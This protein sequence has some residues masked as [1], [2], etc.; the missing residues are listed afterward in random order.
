MIKI[1]F[2]RASLFILF[3]VMLALYSFDGLSVRATSTGPLITAKASASGVTAA[4]T[5]DDD[6]D[7]DE[8]DFEFRGVIEAL[9]NTPGFIGDWTVSGRTVR[10]GSATEIE[11]EDG[12]VMVGATVEVEGF[13]QTDNSVMAKEIEVES[14]PG[15]E[16]EFEGVVE[17]LPDTMGRIGDWTVSGTVVH[18][19]AATMIKQEGAPVAVG[20]KVE[21]EGSKRADGSVDAFQIEVEDDIDDDD[22]DGD[23]EFKGAIESLPDTPGRIGEWS[24][25]GRKVNVTAA[26][27]INPNAASVAVG[28]VVEVEGIK[29]M[30]AQGS[31]IDAKE[32]EV[33][34]R[35]GAG[36]NFVQFH[37]TVETLPGTPGQIGVWTVSG[38]MVNVTANTKIEMDGFPVAVGSKVEVKGALN[39]DGSINAAKIE[40]EDRD[41]VDDEFEFKGVI[42][43][44]PSTPDLVGDWKVSGRTVRVNA[45][46]EIERDYGMVMVG[47]FVEVEGALQ[48]DNS[49][50]AAEIE[51]KQGR[52]GGAYMNFNQVTTVSAAG[53]Q[54]ENAPG[55]IV[56]AFGVNMSSTTAF[57]TTQPLPYSL[58]NV[59]VVVD[60]KLARLFFVSRN[61][62]NYQ[63]PS[64]I[65]SGSAN[66]VVMNNGQMVS[67]G[68]I[69]VSDVA[70]SI[71]TANASGSGAPAG[72]LLRV[73][74]TG[75]Q[76]FE[77]LFRFDA[78]LGQLVPAPIVR[79][80]GEQLFLIL[81]GTGFGRV[82]NTDGNP[83]NGVAENV[84]VTIGGV[85]APVAFAGVAPN[86]V[87][88]AQ[89]NILIPDTAP[90]NPAT[91]V[92]VS[93]RDRLNNVKRANTVNISLQ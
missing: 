85:N 5:E 54:E 75:R 93:A 59:S 84:Q 6:D 31:V 19:S 21:V 36:G 20:V 34:N 49:V 56:S 82:A 25:G 23:V 53:Y 71:F 46:T 50:I 61:Q 11:Q 2:N 13:V 12:Q 37:G 33:K 45:A 29:R 32:I 7:D 57:A 40:V 18:V 76:V 81:F 14:G 42:E 15:N 41:D 83:A 55:A 17:V 24:V 92:V 16:F 60:G 68:V 27:K 69:K 65:P 62:L 67:Q 44:L 26:T 52:A 30:D 88:L 28:F 77:P 63:V 3:G 22:D 47:A 90:A 86:F 51:V 64:N 48:A 8:G 70:L 78:S 74:A 72:V 58:G 10:V 73:S 9:P 39:A 89:L 80:A 35:G 43:M 38:R 79:G 4:V 66:V 1:S 91:P 87:G